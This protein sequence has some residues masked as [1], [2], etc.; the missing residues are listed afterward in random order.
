MVP[1][2][3]RWFL[4]AW[5]ALGAVLFVLGIWVRGLGGPSRDHAPLA[6][7][8]PTIAEPMQLLSR[9][10]ETRIDGRWIWIAP[11]HRERWE[12]CVRRPFELADCPRLAEWLATRDGAETA[13]LIGEL[14]RG[15]A[16]EGLTALSLVF[17]LARR[18]AWK[19][20]VFDTT[21]D[22]AE[23]A[24]LLETWLSIWAPVSANDPL[25]A[26][27]AR[28]AFALWG[29][30]S[31]ELVSAPLFGSDE[32]AASH[33]RVFADSLTHARGPAATDFGR[34]L[35]E[36]SPRALASL[37]DEDDFLRGLAEESARLFPELDGGCGQ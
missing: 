13:L 32:S 11:E 12:R 25:L 24:R 7:Q 16:E 6:A 31:A 5:V 19:A 27:P 2:D 36:S 1:N 10:A 23:L 33:A 18:G 30:V 14:S 21:A 26:E 3:A 29:R 15:K 8:T 4:R 37:L 20:G 28:A 17:E 9:A 35:A 22:A 34:A